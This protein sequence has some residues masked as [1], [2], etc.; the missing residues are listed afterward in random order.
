MRVTIQFIA[1]NKMENKLQLFLGYF[2]CTCGILFV[3]LLIHEGIHILQSSNPQQLCIGI[4]GNAIASVSV[5][6]FDKNTE[7][8]AYIIAT[9]FVIINFWLVLFPLFLKKSN[10]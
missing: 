6:D 9:L 8:Y 2:F 3:A 7:I 5:D 10:K 1:K 4:N